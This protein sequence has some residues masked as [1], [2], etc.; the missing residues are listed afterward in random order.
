MADRTG[1]AAELA[2]ALD[3]IVR[4][5]LA[6]IRT[7]ATPGDDAR[8]YDVAFLA[9][10][11]DAVRVLDRAVADGRELLALDVLARRALAACADLGLPEAL[12]A[13]LVRDI[14]AAAVA[15]T[16]GVVA[17]WTPNSPDLGDPD[18][19]LLA[20][21]FRAFAENHVAPHAAAI[22]QN[23]LDIPE[24]IIA[25]LAELG[26][27]G[28]SIPTTLGGSAADGAGIMDLRP[29]AIA[30]EELS[31]V[32]LGAAGS[33]ITRPEIL[34][35][36]LLRGGTRDQQKQWLPEIAS[37]AAMVAVA[38]TEPNAGSDVAGLRMQ[39][40]EDGE[41]FR[42]RGAKTWCTF[43]GR[44]ELVMVL[45]RTEPDAMLGARG[46]S[47]F[48]V[49]KERAS[50]R[51]FRAIQP[52]GGAITGRAIPTIGYRGMH[53]FELEFDD[54][55][56]PLG[57]LIGGSDW[58]G[59]GFHLQMDAFAAGRL[60]TAARAVGLMQGATE[61][62]F[63]YAAERTA[64]GSPIIDRPLVRR[65]LGE[66]AAVTHLYRSYTLD[67][68]RNAASDRGGLRPAMAK[69]LS[70]RA[71]EQVSRDAMQ[72][73]GGYGY[74]EEYSVSRMFVDARVLSIF[75]GTE[76]VLAMKVIGRRLLTDR[77]S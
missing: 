63:A 6:E 74:A 13:G 18:L 39:A 72:L 3:G 71:A 27:F 58:R 70:C 64:F 53:S 2:A 56:V 76:E 77:N 22:H 40:V 26:A 41:T 7:T 59:R 38:V 44:A 12:E 37:G 14:R 68:A 19:Q 16:D 4:R 52:A 21:S 15:A 36:A 28:M 67:V 5:Q 29:M 8:L 73:H 69:A 66:L 17:G 45:A 50:G 49:E 35:R 54:W 60:Q 55:I 20:Q 75:E 48:V 11:A 57:A 43:A 10:G 32:S 33:L 46:L 65:M 24:S 9:A 30:T 51:K 61:A 31:R 23:D 42:L 1:R 47:L 34:A 62:A 25:G